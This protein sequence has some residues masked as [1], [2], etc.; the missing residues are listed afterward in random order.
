MNVNK[1]IIIGRLGQDPELKTLESGTTV[2][3]LSLATSQSWV[4]REGQRKEKTEWTKVTLFGKSA[5]A[6]GKYLSKGQLAFV[7]GKLTTNVWEDKEGKKQYQT[8]VNGSRIEF[9][10]KTGEQ[11]N[12][13]PHAQTDLGPAPS[14]DK[15]Q[16]IPF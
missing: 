13:K 3:N 2:C 4:D 12:S 11:S 10:P 1:V 6:A 15:S 7:E 9:G 14:F 5:E 16:E 8:V